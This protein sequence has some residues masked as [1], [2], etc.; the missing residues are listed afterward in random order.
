M[1][2]PCWNRGWICLCLSSCCFF[3]PIK[4]VNISIFVYCLLYICPVGLGAAS[5]I[6]LPKES[7]ESQ[8]GN[9]LE[10]RFLFVGQRE[11]ISLLI[12]LETYCCHWGLL[13]KPDMSVWSLPKKGL[14]QTGNPLQGKWQVFLWA[15]MSTL[16]HGCA[17]GIIQVTQRR[18]GLFYTTGLSF[19]IDQICSLRC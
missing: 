14:H 10:R 1:L 11:G 5:V 3:L 2:F 13:G 18:P 15:V 16:S 12:F 9:C 19:K 17:S 6:Y 8:Q 4:V 7:L